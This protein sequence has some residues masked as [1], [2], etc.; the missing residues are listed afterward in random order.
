M[1]TGRGV[2]ICRRR[3][4]GFTGGETDMA[5]LPCLKYLVTYVGIPI[6]TYIITLKLMTI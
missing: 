3:Q 5:Y 2:G 1:V 6:E 4:R